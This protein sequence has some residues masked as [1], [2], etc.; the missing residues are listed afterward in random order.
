MLLAPL[1]HEIQ[2]STTPDHAFEVYVSRFG[3]WWNPLYTAHPDTFSGA[4]IEPFVGGR[5]FGSHEPEGDY[6]WGRVTAFEPGLLLRY[7]STLAQPSEAPSEITVQFHATHTGCRV[8]FDHGGWNPING[9][10]REKF[11]D[12]PLMLARFAELAEG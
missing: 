11:G 12:W 4:T 2:L 5:V 10:F 9:A 7:E 3:E 8:T 1:T 6:E